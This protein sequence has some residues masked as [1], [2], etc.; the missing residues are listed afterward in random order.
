MEV[1]RGG[2]VAGARRDGAK[3]RTLKPCF[4]KK[5]LGGSKDMIALGGVL[6][7]SGH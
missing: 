3:A 1:K 6:G 4:G 2:C 7:W 5:R